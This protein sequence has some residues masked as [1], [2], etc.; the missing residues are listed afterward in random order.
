M[1]I[2]TSH[3]RQQRNHFASRLTLTETGTSGLNIHEMSI[4]TQSTVQEIRVAWLRRRH[5]SEGQGL[6]ERTPVDCTFQLALGLHYYPPRNVSGR[7][8]VALAHQHCPTR[9]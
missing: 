6:F 3:P 9:E 1:D 8:P 5:E 7:V 4:D 2:I